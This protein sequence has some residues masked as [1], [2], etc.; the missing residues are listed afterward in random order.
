M[1]QIKKSTKIFEFKENIVQL[2]IDELKKTENF[3]KIAIFQIHNKEIFN[4]LEN[5]LNN[6][7]KVDIFTL[8]YDSINDDI[9]NNVIPLFENLKN[10]GAILHFCKW[11]IGDPERTTTTIGRW[12]LFHGKFIVTDKSA[13]V[14]SANLMQEEELD[15]VIIFRDD[16]NK[17]AEYNK[18]FDELIELFADGNNKENIRA[19]ISNS[20]LP[21]DEIIKLFA[22]PKSIET[23]THKNF[24]IRHY[25]VSIFSNKPNISEGLYITPFDYKGREILKLL[26]DEAEKFIYISTES[27]TDLEFP[28][29]LIQK[30]LNNNKIEIKLLL[31]VSSMDFPDRIQKMIPELLACNIEIRTYKNIHAKFIATDKHIAISSINLNKMNLGFV[32]TNSKF[33][34]ENTETI[35][36][37]NDNELLEEGKIKFNNNFNHFPDI[38]EILIN[39]YK[40]IIK[41]KFSLFNLRI[42]GDVKDLF[43]RLIIQKKIEIEE[44]ILHITKITHKIMTYFSNNSLVTKKYFILALILYYLTERKHDIDQLNE[45]LII[46]DIDI[47]TI[48]DSIMVLLDND[49]IEKDNDF[50]RINLNKLF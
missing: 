45:K 13:M 40:T 47:D 36:I 6:G 18:K 49:F 31:G 26:I 30:S 11:N 38:K 5:K 50:Y 3:I 7:V 17:I 21:H 25:P 23:D 20:G 35:A 29:Y 32:S 12:Y 22:L 34:R 24:W 42:K 16:T 8:P 27:F 2:I 48:N 1:N 15:A 4:T 41:D 39:K 33:W 14:L 37:Y 28:K 10:K 19:K 46:L 43:A 44:F 9:R